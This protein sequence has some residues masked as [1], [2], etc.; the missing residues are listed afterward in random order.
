MRETLHADESLNKSSRE[1]IRTGNGAWIKSG[2]NNPI[3]VFSLGKCNLNYPICFMWLRPY[4]LF[5]DNTSVIFLKGR[6]YEADTHP[7][8]LTISSS[9]VA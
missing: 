5:N 1:S 7:S 3:K 6:A 4:K 9:A 2:T 8:V